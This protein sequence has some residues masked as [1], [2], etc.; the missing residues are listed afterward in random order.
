M[1]P[2]EHAN[3]SS[4]LTEAVLKPPSMA[5]TG[6]AD[7]ARHGH[8]AADRAREQ[9]ERVPPL[10]RLLRRACAPLLRR[11]FDLRVTGVE[12]LPASG[13]FIVASNHHNYVD[14]VVLAVA[15]P[16]PIGFVVMPRVYNASPLHPS[17]HRCVGSIPVS[18]ER[19]DPGAIRRVLRVLESG[20]VIGIFPEG[21]FS[22][23]GRLVS[24][25]PGVAMIALRSGIPVVPAAI[26]GTYEALVGRRFHVPRRHPLSVRFGAPMRFGR[27]R[28][29][30]VTRA[31]REDVTRRIMAEIAALLGTDAM[32]E[33]ATTDQAGTS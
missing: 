2:G 14:G 25:Q 7:A 29:H 21:P 16:R 31:Q 13:P 28:H 33:A 6:V 22:R 8:E 30:P 1:P 11:L 32:P 24:G 10:Y 23:E 19:P 27:T 26:E 17:F 15:L 4:L 9:D 5:V 3:S 12:H 18:L 20:R